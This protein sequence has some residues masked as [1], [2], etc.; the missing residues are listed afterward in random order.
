MPKRPKARVDRTKQDA[1]AAVSPGDPDIVQRFVEGLSSEE[2]M[3]VV[4]KAELYEGN[5]DNMV[6]DL[7]ARL[8]DRPYIFKLANRIADDLQRICR[9]REFERQANVDLSLYVRLDP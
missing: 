1:P 6:A 2:R 4:L 9:L 7:T 5:W 3:L 8:E